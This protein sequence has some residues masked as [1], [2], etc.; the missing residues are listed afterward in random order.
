V[1]GKDIQKMNDL[2]FLMDNI[3]GKTVR[4]V[5]ESGYSVSMEFDDGT[6]VTFEAGDSWIDINIEDKKLWVE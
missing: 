4:R 5:K 6:V 2:K 3:R 1:L